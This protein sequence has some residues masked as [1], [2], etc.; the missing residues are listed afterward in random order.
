M[1]EGCSER[2]SGLGFSLLWDLSGPARGEG[3][4]PSVSGLGEKEEE[5]GRM[6]GT[7]WREHLL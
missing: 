7:G 6:R 1:W 4:E 2:L 3:G 5:A